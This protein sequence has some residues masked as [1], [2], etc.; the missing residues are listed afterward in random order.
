[1]TIYVPR[2]P[3]PTPHCGAIVEGTG[4]CP[5]CRRSRTARRAPEQRVYTQE[6]ARYSKD[7]LARFPWCGQRQDG[8]FHAEHSRCWQRGER[9]RAQVTDHILSIRNGGAMFDPANHQSL[10]TSCNTAKDARRG[11]RL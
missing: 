8:A 5:K 7:W 6:W 1:M 9:V 3:C 11:A 4:A 2:H 10:C